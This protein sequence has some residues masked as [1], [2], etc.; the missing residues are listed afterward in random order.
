MNVL[1]LGRARSGK[2]MAINL[3]RSTRPETPSLLFS[4][5]C[6]DGDKDEY[7]IPK[8]FRYEYPSETLIEQMKLKNTPLS[9]IIDDIATGTETSALLKWNRQHNISA[10]VCITYPWGDAPPNEDPQEKLLDKSMFDVVIITSPMTTS[11]L[12]YL[13]N[14]YFNEVIPE[15]TEFLKI[16]K[17]CSSQRIM[18]VLYLNS[19][20]VRYIK[21]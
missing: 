15:L 20:D 8:M 6:S 9:V 14:K 11:H 12:T 10:Y 16:Y 4:G 21:L 19:K 1:C 17:T 18:M 13:H 7:K 3:I 2:T 5:G